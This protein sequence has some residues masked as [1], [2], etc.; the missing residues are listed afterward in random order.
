[1]T[2]K[3]YLMGLVYP[4]VRICLR[5]VDL[6][7]VWYGTGDGPA[8]SGGNGGVMPTRTTHRDGSGFGQG[9]GWGTGSRKG[10]GKSILYS[11]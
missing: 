3:L 8:A 1:L 7:E 11:D 9:W 10:Q 5:T 2:D 4:N 6:T